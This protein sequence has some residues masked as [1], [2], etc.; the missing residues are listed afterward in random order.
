MHTNAFDHRAKGGVHQ[1]RAHDSGNGHDSA[2][3]ERVQR[4]CIAETGQRIPESIRRCAGLYATSRIAA[5]TGSQYTLYAPY[6]TGQAIAHVSRLATT[7]TINCSRVNGRETAR[8]GRASNASDKK[9]IAMLTDI[10]EW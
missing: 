9:Q 4:L 8:A 10:A 2:E 5:E 3:S 1:S 7:S 6:D